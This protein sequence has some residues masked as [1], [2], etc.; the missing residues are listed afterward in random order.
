[1]AVTVAV[2]SSSLWDIDRYFRETHCFH[3]QLIN[4]SSATAV[5]TPDSYE[6][7]VQST[8]LHEVW[9]NKRKP[10]LQKSYICFQGLLP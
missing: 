4:I 8:R 5:V 9:Y 3:Y 10:F 7:S 1:M 6:T 2:V